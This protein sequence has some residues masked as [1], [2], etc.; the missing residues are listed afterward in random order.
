MAKRLRLIVCT[1]CETVEPVEWCAEKA[2]ADPDCGHAQCEQALQARMIEHTVSQPT[3]HYFHADLG[4]FDVSEDEWNKLT[5]RKEI[6]KNL[7]PPG[8]AV[9]YGADM[10]D[11][12]STYHQDAS[13]CWK[14][15]N[16]TRNC[17][18]Y[19]AASKRLVPPTRELRKD[20]GMETRDKKRPTSAFLCDYCPVQSIVMQRQRDAAGMY[21]YNE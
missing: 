18:D 16:R 8:S 13:K 14:Q 2:G 10:Y 4:L 19:K 6:L 5:T 20:L 12:K 1:R 7:R 17:Q 21:D 3:G 15:H 11:L 9:P